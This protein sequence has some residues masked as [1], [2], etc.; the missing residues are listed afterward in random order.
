MSAESFPHRL[1]SVATLV[2][3]SQADSLHTKIL[4]GASTPFRAG[5]SA[6]RCDVSLS[7]QP[8]ERSVE[9]ADRHPAPG[10]FFNLPADRHSV[11]VVA[12][13]QNRQ[14]NDPFEFTKVI[15]M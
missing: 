13:T 12:Q 6:P 11:G 8:S 2:E 10:P 4:P 9:R 15:A 3:R 7:L 1:Q 5:I 14:E